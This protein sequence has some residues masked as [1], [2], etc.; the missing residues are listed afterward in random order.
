M[1]HRLSITLAAAATIAALNTPEVSAQEKAWTLSDC[2]NYAI[3][4]NVT[5]RQRE[6][7]KEQ[8]END[9]STAKGRNLP[10]V[11][12]Y[13]GQRFDFGRG[14][15]I[16]NTYENKNTRNTS[17]A[18]TAQMTLFDGL[19]SV[20][21]VKVSRLNLAAATEDLQAAKEDIGIQVAQAYL[22]VLS[23]KEVAA[24]AAEQAELS[25]TQLA[26]KEA[27][28]K[29]GKTS[30]AEV[31]A[32]R[33]LVAQ[34][35]MT[36]VK[37]DGDYNLA[38]LDLSQ[39]LELGSP[40]SLNVAQPDTSDILAEIALPDEVYGEALTAKASIRAAQVRSECAEQQ[41]KVARGGYSPT[42]NLQADV[43]TGYY[44]VSGQDVDSFGDQIS[45]NLNKSI[46]LSLNIP[47]FNRFATRNGVR[48]ARLTY[49]SSLVELED[50]RK[51]LY[52]E[53]QQAYYNA[54]AARATYE[55]SVAASESAEAAF[56]LADGKYAEGL[57]SSTE[58]AEAR[59]NRLTALA[60]KIQYK[61][62]L[63]FRVKILD[64]YR[65][66]ALE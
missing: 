38:L 28:L 60:N 64:F 56:R 41:I 58:Y 33:S 52:K 53:I 19:Q 17:F 18:V 43:S 62:N 15:T 7:I 2:V 24:A 21:G 66:S 37:A 46:A 61:Y 57:S 9:L 27:L 3:E 44:G 45:N 47:I 30:E 20:N 48:D 14:L 10:S 36:A 29:N 35:E 12:A 8:R 63:I 32:A 54:I 22:Q 23:A 13:V 65:G 50:T 16:N 4:H 34:D 55:S 42:L 51:K 5:I 40:D 59:T 11:G 26:R 31:Y 6:I 1:N 49:T 25:R 39:L